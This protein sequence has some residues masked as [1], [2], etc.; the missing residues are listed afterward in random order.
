M[1]IDKTALGV[2]TTKQLAARYGVTPQTVRLWVRAGKITPTRIT[3]KTHV[4]ASVDVERFERGRRGE[5]VA[6]ESGTSA[7]PVSPP[8]AWKTDYEVYEREAHAALTALARDEKYLE[9]LKQ[10]YPG[11][12]VVQSMNKAWKTHWQLRKT[13][14]R[15][16]SQEGDVIDWANKTMKWL[17]YNKVEKTER[18]GG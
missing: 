7:P 16:R 18:N 3:P 6:N 5:S 8:P 10:F 2:L 12:N 4:F 17:Q 11:Y 14:E 15:L 13:W 1:E 9:G